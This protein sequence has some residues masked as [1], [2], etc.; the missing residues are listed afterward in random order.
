MSDFLVGE[1]L[2]REI[3]FLRV[4]LSSLKESRFSYQ[5]LHAWQSNVP[6]NFDFTGRDRRTQNAA[7]ALVE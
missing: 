1:G 2:N 4:A 5:E 7:G 6:Q 3:D